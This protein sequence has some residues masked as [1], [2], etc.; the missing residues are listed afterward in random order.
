M[1][2]YV[3]EK[4]LGLKMWKY[5]GKQRPDFAIEP[6]P[7]QE[8]VWDYPRPPKL[9]EVHRLVEVHVNER[10]IARSTRAFRILE[11]A[12]PPTFYLPPADVELSLLERCAER[13]YCEWKGVATYWV[14]KTGADRSRPIAWSYETPSKAF[15]R[16]K[17]HFCFY[18]SRVKALVD[19]E[20]VRAQSSD[21]YG[22]W[23]TDE[24]VGPFKGE[25]GT[26]GW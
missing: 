1:R 20:R 26:S 19:G 11:T 18:P 2:S 4:S 5:T 8:S 9:E 12:S 6:G 22:G 7:D 24:I 16:V 17:G 23:V 14:L 3:R 21:F 25:P 10:E 13:S 15:E